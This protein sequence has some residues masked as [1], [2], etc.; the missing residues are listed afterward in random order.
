MISPFSMQFK[1]IN[2]RK[3]SSK[4]WMLCLK[5]YLNQKIL[6]IKVIH[7]NR[8][9]MEVDIKINQN[10]TI[11]AKKYKHEKVLLLWFRNAYVK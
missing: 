3:K 5:W 2:I 6:T 11:F 9:K 7:K 1:T 8:I 4:Q 10:E